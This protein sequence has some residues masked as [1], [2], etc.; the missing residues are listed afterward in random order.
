M[1][2]INSALECYQSIIRETLRGLS[3]VKNIAD[4]IIVHGCGQ[5]EHDLHAVELM[6]RLQEKG[7]T[8]NK[9]KCIFRMP[10]LKFVGHTLSKHGIGPTE[11]TVKAVR[12]ARAPQSASEVRSFLGLVN[13]NARYIADLATLSEPLRRLTR[14]SVTFNW[15]KEQQA[16]FEKLKTALSE[17]TTLAYFSNNAKTKVVADASPVGIAAVL[18][19]EQ[20]GIQRAI[21]YASRS[22]SDVERRYSQT[23]KEA[24]A[25]VLACE[26]FHMY[27]YG[28]RFELITDH[29]PLE[30]IYSARSKPSARIERWV[31][32]LQPY[33]FNVIYSTRP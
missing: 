33:E 24:L 22:L 13:F 2:G 29:K 12:E 10:K 27:L 16:A 4:D 19:Q 17:A 18:V 7:L 9:E 1:F 20:D 30:C 15:G 28:R 5:K 14:K 11:E 21:Y 32:R 23:E 25:L 6:K 3:G 31:L 26:R 8:L